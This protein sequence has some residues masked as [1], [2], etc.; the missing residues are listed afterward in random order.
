[1]FRVLSAG[2]LSSCREGAQISGVRTCLLEEVL[3]HSPEVL[4]SHRESC[5]VGGVSADSVPKVL[6]YWRGLEGTCDPGQAGF[7]ASLINSVSSPV[8]LDWCRSRVP[9]TRSL[10]IPWRV[11]WGPWEC[12]QTPSPR[13]LGA[14]VDQKGNLGILKA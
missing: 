13:F 11:L 14:V 8:R 12:P 9:L 5:G 1:V 10:K 6:K 3:I 7:S 2:K 4:I